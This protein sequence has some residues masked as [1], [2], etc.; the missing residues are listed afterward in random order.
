MQANHHNKMLE[1]ILDEW[2]TLNGQSRNSNATDCWPDF[3]MTECPTATRKGQGDAG[4]YETGGFPLRSLHPGTRGIETNDL[5]GVYQNSPL[6]VIPDSSDDTAHAGSTLSADSKFATRQVRLR[7]PEGFADYLDRQPDKLRGAVFVAVVFGQIPTLQ[8]PA[9]YARAV[10]CLQRL[11]L[12]LLNAL[13]RE[14]DE[15][16]ATGARKAI[17]LINQLS[18]KSSPGCAYR[19]LRM[20][21]EYADALP[22][23]L[24]QRE[25]LV[26]I[27]VRAST[28]SI[29]LRHVVAV[30]PSLD[31]LRNRLVEKLVSGSDASPQEEVRNVAQAVLELMEHGWKGVAK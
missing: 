13:D 6:D 21:V 20:P 12:L 27:A 16:L 26:R 14:L 28:M 4:D 24:S 31:E 17:K 3:S 5:A 30:V 7:L 15:K 23:S 11:A 18:R 9:E 2:P 1:E 22:T 8:K 29:S 10:Q 25:Y 19:R